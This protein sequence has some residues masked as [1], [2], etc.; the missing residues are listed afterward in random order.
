MILFHFTCLCSLLQW[1]WK[2]PI[3]NFQWKIRPVKNNVRF[4]YVPWKSVWFCFTSTLWVHFSHKTEKFL[5][6]KALKNFNS[7]FFFKYGV[8][9]QYVPWKMSDF[10]S[11]S[12]FGFTLVIKLRN[13]D[14][15]SHWKTL[16]VFFFLN[17]VSDINIS[18]EKC[19]I[20]FIFIVWVHFSHKTE[21]FWFWR[22]LKYFNVFFHNKVWLCPVKQCLICFKLHC[23]LKILTING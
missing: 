7:F 16:I 23:L 3:I 2:V 22:S 9:H 12:L 8:R 11:F 5:F 18:H 13:F 1:N 17:M 14:F 4:E 20:F 19:L 21:K 10:F 6:W 15:E